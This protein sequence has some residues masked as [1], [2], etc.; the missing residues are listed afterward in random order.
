MQTEPATIA[1]ISFH[2]TIRG[3][4]IWRLHGVTTATVVPAATS[5]TCSKPYYQNRKWLW[6]I[7]L[8][9]KINLA[10][11]LSPLLLSFLLINHILVNTGSNMQATWSH[12]FPSEGIIY[13]KSTFL[14]GIIDIQHYEAVP[15]PFTENQR[16]VYNCMHHLS[17]HAHIRKIVKKEQTK[18]LSPMSD[19]SLRGSIVQTELSVTLVTTTSI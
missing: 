14:K 1:S 16:E 17:S 7:K 18:P 5:V 9:L 8:K 15:I 10:H 19:E 6:E 4:D 13:Y 2:Q 3:V 12:D 11:I